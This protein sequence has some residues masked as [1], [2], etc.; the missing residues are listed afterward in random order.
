RLLETLTGNVTVALQYDRL[1][2]AVRQLESLQQELERKA[3][4]DSLTQLANRSLFHNRLEHALHSR[5]PG[6]CVLL[7]DIDEF[8]AVNDS[9]GHHAG[10]ELLRAVAER[11]RGCLREGDTAARLGGDEFALL[12]DRSGGEADFESRIDVAGERVRV[13]VSIGIAVGSP[14]KDGPEEMLR[15]ADVALYEAKRRGKSQYRVF[16]PSLRDA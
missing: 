7:L 13:H 5:R 3:L 11:L 1:E 2:Q 14:G 4:Y 6:V 10:D 16:H 9:H 15:K 12:L 8:K